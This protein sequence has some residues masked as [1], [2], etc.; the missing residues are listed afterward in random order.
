LP[1][2]RGE[3][4]LGI[5]AVLG[6]ALLERHRDVLIQ[7]LLVRLAAGDSASKETNLTPLQGEYSGAIDVGQA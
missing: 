1:E 7:A 5:L 6:A 2:A 3:S 4:A